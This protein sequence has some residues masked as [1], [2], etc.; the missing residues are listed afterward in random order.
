MGH[1]LKALIGRWFA[2]ALLGTLL[3]TP[4]IP[5]VAASWG[6]GHKLVATAWALVDRAYVDPTFNHHNWWS[7]RQKVLR[8]QFDTLQ[9]A[10]QAI[11]TMLAVLDDPFTRF[12]D[13]DH[14]RTLQSNT[15]GELNGVGLQIVIDD[16]QRLTV[17][18]P[19]AG[20][21]AERAGLRPND[22]ILAIDH[23]PTQG[24]TLDQAAEKMRGQ[25]GEPVVLQVEREGAVFEVSLIREAIPIHA[26]A[27]RWLTPEQVQY[28][29]LTQFNGNA[30]AEVAAA[31]QAGEQ[32]HAQ[33]YILD[34]RNNPGG[35]LQAA[36][37]IAQM[38]L[39][40]G[41]IVL[42][43]DRHG[44]QDSISATHQ[45]QPLL[46]RAPLVVLVD[47]GTASASEVLAGS[48]QD[49]HRA[50][51]VGSRTFGKGLIQSLFD[52]PDGSGLAITTAR[53]LTPSGRDIHKQGIEPDRVVVQE[54][55][56]ADQI[57]TAADQQFQVALQML[58]TQLGES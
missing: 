53:Y 22:H 37:T 18:A 15:S 49:N 50:L 44:I 40:K 30:V 58:L 25:P 16:Q 14:Y 47:Q 41:D 55:L 36:I 19:M 27:S 32:H 1:L 46:T 6:E 54:P 23:Q 33:G 26:V 5:S 12:L 20:S 31:I 9:D 42:V 48:L 28:I 52:L 7:V 57:G 17:V 29:R 56:P 45:D 38:W 3:L 10:Y 39:D 2:V 21:P 24:W 13:P 51:L 4:G 43:T 8:Q 35:L 34:L 11:E